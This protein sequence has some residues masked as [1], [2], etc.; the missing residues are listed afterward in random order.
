MN[1]TGIRRNLAEIQERINAAA[2]RVGRDPAEIKLVGVS[3]KHPPTLIRSGVA[4]GLHNFG[5]SYA[6]ELVEKAD[7][8]SALENKIRW[9]FIGHLQR[10]KVAQILPHVAMIHAVDSERLARQIDRHAEI[11]GITIPVLLQVNTS[12]EASKYGCYPGGAVTLAERVMEMKHVDVQGLMTLAARAND[13]V[14]ARPKFQLL[15]DTRDLVSD[16]LGRELPE[17]SMG[18]SED[19]EIAIEEGSTYVRLGTVLFGSRPA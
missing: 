19:F 7:E 10:N 9:H 13:A 3:K 12:G 17:L 2:G 4:A 5:E 1:K 18:M 8:L 6:Q 11:L 16:R 15:R 14:D